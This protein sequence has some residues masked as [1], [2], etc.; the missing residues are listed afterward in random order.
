MIVACNKGHHGPVHCV[1]FSPEGDSY[2]SGSEDGTIRIWQTG[3]LTRDENDTVKTN[4]STGKVRATGEVIRRKIEGFKLSD[5]GK[6]KDEEVVGKNKD[7]EV[8]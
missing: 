8:A 7:K 2:A 3:S 1:R 5:E 4:G 6:T